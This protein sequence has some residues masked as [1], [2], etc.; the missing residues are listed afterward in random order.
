MNEK[1]E[2]TQVIDQNRGFYILIVIAGINLVYR[3]CMAISYTVRG[4][5]D[6]TDIIS[7]LLA[8]G[9]GVMLVAGMKAG[10]YAFVAYSVYRLYNCIAGFVLD[11][12]SISS[13]GVDVFWTVYYIAVIAFYIAASVTLFANK[14]VNSYINGE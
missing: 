12:S 3:L 9:I 14:N 10:K 8:L 6:F 4:Y 1:S 2:K 13:Q 11:I 5:G 7:V